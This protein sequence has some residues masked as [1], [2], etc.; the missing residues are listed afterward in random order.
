[1]KDFRK[2]EAELVA[3]LDAA[4]IPTK[5]IDGNYYATMIPIDGCNRPDDC[6]MRLRTSGDL[7]CF[8]CDVRIKGACV[9][10]VGLPITSLAKRI[11]E[12]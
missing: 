4:D 6:E 2:I 7:K 12:L 9:E 3:A 11:A 1:M 5:R 10:A 8:D